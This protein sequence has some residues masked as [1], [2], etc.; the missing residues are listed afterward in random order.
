MRK[1]MT[2]LLV[3]CLLCAVCVPALGEGCYEVIKS[4]L[5]DRDSYGAPVTVPF[6]NSDK[7]V[8]L[9]YNSE[10]STLNLAGT[11]TSGSGELC[12]WSNVDIAHALATIAALCNNWNTL[13]DCLGYGYTLVICITTDS[14]S[15]SIFIDSSAKASQFIQYLRDNLGLTL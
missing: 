9:Q 5:S 4:V 15:D 8:F 6:G 14:S 11:N 13:E 12:L 1:L 3:A 2:L 7:Y 10:D